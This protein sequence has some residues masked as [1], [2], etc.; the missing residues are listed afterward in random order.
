MAGGSRSFIQRRHANLNSGRRVQNGFA[1]APSIKRAMSNGQEARRFRR[2][3]ECRRSRRSRPSETKIRKS[4]TAIDGD[5][6]GMYRRFIDRNVFRRRPF[7]AQ[8]LRIEFDEIIAAVE[9]VWRKAMTRRLAV[10]S[11]EIR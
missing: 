7:S 6:A 5:E 9:E 11:P 2:V 10:A 1:T 8:F 4:P 3:R